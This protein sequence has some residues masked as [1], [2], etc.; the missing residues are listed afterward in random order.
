MTTTATKAY[1]VFSAGNALMEATIRVD[2][3]ALKSIGLPKSGMRLIDATGL[4]SI[5]QE[6]R[7]NLQSIVPAGA[8][9]NVA[10][11]VTWLGGRSFFNG[12]IGQDETGNQ[13]ENRLAQLGVHTRLTRGPG[14]TGQI[15][16][17]VTPDHERSMLTHLGEAAHFSV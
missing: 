17:F 9:C 15:L 3:E 12:K 16:S 1:D 13:Y 5:T 8:E 4:L 2:D 11:G 7:G 10:T 6:W 14:H